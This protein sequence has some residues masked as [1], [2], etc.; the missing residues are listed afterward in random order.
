MANRCYRS[1]G[2]MAAVN[3]RPFVPAFGRVL[4]MCH[5]RRGCLSMSLSH[6]DP[7]LRSWSSRN[8][9]R[10]IEAGSTVSYRMVSAIDIG[11]T[12]D[13]PINICNRSIIVEGPTFPAATVVSDT[14]V[15]ETVVY[16]PIKPNIRSP[17]TGMPDVKPSGVTPIA[18]RPE[19]ANFGGVSPV[20]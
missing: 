8:A 13:S 15:A 10:T 18:R 14:A 20:S 4:L 5:L 16:A 12:N 1:A 19:E 9:T 11:V 2:W 3:R 6:G 17:V 7:L